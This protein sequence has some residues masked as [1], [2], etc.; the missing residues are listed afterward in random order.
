MRQNRVGGNPSDREAATAWLRMRLGPELDAGRVMVT[1]GTQSALMLLLQALVGSRGVLAAEALT[2]V[3]L[4]T[5]A[6]RLG[7][8]LVSVALDEEGIIPGAFEEVCRCHQPRALY[9][10]PTVHNPTAAVMS[11][12][13]RRDVIAVARKYGVLIIED[14]VLGAV[15]PEAPPPIAALAPDTWYVMSLSKCYAMGLRLAYLVAPSSSE[16]QALLEPVRRLSW[17]FPNSLS[18][19]IAS[20]WALDGNGRRIAAAV[21]AEADAR[22]RLAANILDMRHARTAP[23]ALHIWLHTPDQ[24]S[25]KDFA[26]AA[27]RRGVLVR[28]ADLF[29]VD[30]TPPGNHVR[31]SLTAPSSREELRQGLTALATLFGESQP[32]ELIS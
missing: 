28:P 27:Q 7:I 26:A 9:C 31:V 22:Q 17:W 18:V 32:R 15:H 20:R 1:N 24:E 30:V 10:N 23:G 13:R 6:A 29:A 21:C 4:R 3:V 11:E 5:I 25:S 19:E 8:A 12:A 14:D 2:Y 16:A